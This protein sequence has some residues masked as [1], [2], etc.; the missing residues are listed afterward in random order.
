M[1]NIMRKNSDE[2]AQLWRQRIRIDPEVLKTKGNEVYKQGKFEDA[3]SL[4][5]G[6]IQL[7]SNKATYHCN[8]S[9]A[10]MGL[11]RLPEALVEYEEAILL[12][13]SYT[14]AHHRLAAIY[15]RLGEAEMAIKWNN[16]TP[17][18]DSVLAFQAQALQNQKL[19]PGLY[20]KT[21][22]GCY[23]SRTT[24]TINLANSK[25]LDLQN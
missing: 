6:A 7:D 17:H 10:L 4:F 15:L 5:D 9:A 22:Y 24:E 21:C 18:A 3:L 14:R 16:S 1:G 19:I 11:G 25:T 2:L 8:K 12:E 20:R 13:S 23:T